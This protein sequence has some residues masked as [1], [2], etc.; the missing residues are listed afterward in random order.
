MA[1]FLRRRNGQFNGSIG[2]GITAPPPPL[3]PPPAET[4]E[5]L[6]NL[7][8]A[9]LEADERFLAWQTM[10]K[11]S[12]R[13]GQ[14]DVTD[15]DGTPH[16]LTEGVLDDAARHTFTHGHCHSLALALH[17]ETGFPLVAFIRVDPR[18]WDDEGNLHDT[19]PY[20]GHACDLWEDEDDA[21]YSS[22]TACYDEAN[23]FHEEVVHF[24]VIPGPNTI[25]DATGHY[26]TDTYCYHNSY[27][28][29]QLSNPDELYQILANTGV[30]DGNYDQWLTP[31]P[32]IATT[33]ITPVLNQLISPQ[34]V[35]LTLSWA[36]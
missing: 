12:P 4:P 25:L 13:T 9:F 2:D 7:N 17:A 14:L 24:G 21:Y 31:D 18:R 27:V 20:N 28:A 6:I 30:T 11:S 36:D 26:P 29:Q 19:I 1:R 34:P 23:P 22:C 15:I 10:M 35:G 8:E 33:F 16:R 32:T 5:H 3:L